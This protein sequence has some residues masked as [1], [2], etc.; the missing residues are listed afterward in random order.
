MVTSGSDS[1]TV[2][3][4]PHTWRSVAVGLGLFCL[5]AGLFLAAG[6]KEAFFPKVVAIG[7]VVL[8]GVG[9]VASAIAS[10]SRA[11]SGDWRVEGREPYQP[12]KCNGGDP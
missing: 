8:L 12:N 5:I 10:R 4:A 7:G 9:G 3:P 1:Q 2:P 6:F 11:S